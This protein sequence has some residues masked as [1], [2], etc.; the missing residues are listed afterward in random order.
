MLRIPYCLENWLRDGGKIVSLMSRPLFCSVEILFFCFWSTPGPIAARGIRQIV[1]NH[2]SH[3]VSNPRPTG[4]WHS[5]LTDMLP[6]APCHW[7]V[8]TGILKYIFKVENYSKKEDWILNRWN[9][10]ESR[11]ETKLY[12][13][14]IF[15]S[16]R[17]P[18]VSHDIVTSSCTSLISLHHWFSPFK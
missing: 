14:R 17:V 12:R 16:F 15:P 7:Q 10:T 8:Y 11:L 4:L 1:I 3:Q 9:C 18:Y 5:A 2:S 13:N 6:R